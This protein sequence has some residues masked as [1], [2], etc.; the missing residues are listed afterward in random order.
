MKLV[1]Y[2]PKGAEKPGLID[3]AGNLRDLSGEIDDIG[4]DVLSPDGLDRLRALDPESLPNVDG[5]PRLGPCVAGVSK[6]IA[7]GLN[8]VD[9]A[10]EV[11]AKLPKEPIVFMKA[12]TS[13]SG[14]DDPIEIPRGSVQTDW[15]VEL[16]VIIGTRAKY[17]T[18]ATAMDHVAG[19]ATANDVSER[20]FQLRRSGQ[21]VK[22]KSHDS[23]CPLGP[24]L[25]TAD[26]V[27]DPQALKIWSDLNGERQQDSSTEQ[28]HFGVAQIVS[29][30]S[31]F[32]TLL[33]GDV[34]VTGTPSGVG[35]GQEPPRFLR[36]GDVLEME[37]EGLGRQ[38]QV[39]EAAS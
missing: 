16:A 34:I 23:F 30:L 9:H 35:M 27:P 37:V 6:I 15:E 17:V 28:L 39:C 14:P 26:E 21:W 7:I 10:A 19:Y 13:L 8:Y 29:H 20:D 36:P 5:T 32:M 18:E 33:P 3:A 24:W 38:R 2:G 1:R 22:G 25:V 12:T 31:E 11:G 4:G